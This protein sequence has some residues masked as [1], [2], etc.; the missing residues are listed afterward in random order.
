MNPVLE[1]IDKP[2]V[3]SNL[4]MGLQSS[5]AS[6]TSY[7]TTCLAAIDNAIY[8]KRF[9]YLLNCDCVEL[10]LLACYPM[11]YWSNSWFIG[12]FNPWV[13]SRVT[14]EMKLISMYKFRDGYTQFWEKLLRNE[15]NSPEFSM[16]AIL[17]VCLSIPIN[18]IR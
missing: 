4:N 18:A 3:S 6:Y 11:P 2:Y 7:W 9:G 13:K 17:C 15:G 8:K 5:L 14:L 16:C 1:Y 12:V 10:L